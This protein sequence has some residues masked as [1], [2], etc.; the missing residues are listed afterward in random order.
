[1]ADIQPLIIFIFFVVFFNAVIGLFAI[2]SDNF[3]LSDYTFISNL[4]ADLIKHN[5][6]FT[7][8][9]SIIL[10]PFMVI[11]GIILL[12]K[13]LVLSFTIIP[14]LLNVF[15]IIPLETIV[16]F[17]YVLPLIRGN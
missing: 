10:V 2:S 11:D 14:V 1:M 4:R 7:N 17:G 6:W 15:F 8:I 9:V 3:N 5:N 12:L 13:L 16:F